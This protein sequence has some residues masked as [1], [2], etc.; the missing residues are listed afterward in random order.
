MLKCLRLLFV[1]N[2]RGFIVPCSLTTKIVPSLEKGIQAI[3]FLRDADI[4]N[5]SVNYEDVNNF[6][7]II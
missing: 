1:L 2:K 5:E 3:G 7:K 4:V 6:I